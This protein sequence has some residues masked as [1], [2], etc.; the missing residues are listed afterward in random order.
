VFD[1]D[2]LSRPEDQ[3][4]A[5]LLRVAALLLA[6]HS[7][8]TGL[9]KLLSLLVEKE[10]A[11]A[12]I[13]LL[14]NPSDERLALGVAQGYDLNLLNQLRLIPGEGIEGTVLH[15]GEATQLATP[16]AIAEARTSM[17][18][19]NRNLLDRARL[20]TAQP[21]SAI[22]VP[23]IAEQTN[24]GVL[25]LE[26][27]QRPHA[28]VPEDLTFLRNV[29]D[30][31]ALFI[32]NAHLREAPPTAQ[33]VGDANHL[34][35]ELISSLAHEMRTP[36]TTIKGYS[37]ALLM[38]EASFSP[39][40]CREFLQMIGEECNV[41]E[42]LVHD[43]L[44][45]SIIEA[46]YLKLE[47]RPAALPRLAQS[48]TDEIT[49]RCPLHRFVVDFPTDFPVIDSDPDRIAQVLRNLLD[50]AVKYS[51]DGGLIVVRGE[52]RP[53]EVT[54]SVADPGIGIAPEHLNRLFEKFFRVQ[55][56][57]GQHIVG[58]GLGLPIARSIVEGHGGR[59][60]A[61]SQVG[62]GSTF[63]FTLPLRNSSSGSAEWKES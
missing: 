26:N 36:L 27:R 15:T 31:V 38:E 3:R 29:A 45:S 2:D 52:V 62:Q 17:T 4:L 50:N 33:P 42:N 5:T 46:G 55:S 10:A 47:F 40:T 9:S 57:W 58:S 63:Y 8:D 61:E 25:L 12:G 20:G 23:L 35:S 19:N 37:S 49:H 22:C 14:Y 6:E 43:L 7:L 11:D 54:I 48:V 60:W 51:P 28:F 53:N 39:E 59:I 1:K 24:W 32:K 30:L 21:Q 18:S 34:K 44:E 13:L 41:L 16:V 56:G